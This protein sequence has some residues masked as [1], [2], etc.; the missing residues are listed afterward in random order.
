M[1]PV[2]P[3]TNISEIVS[4]FAKVCRL[5]SIGVFSSENQSHH[6]QNICI[7]NA[8]FC[9][10]VSD[11]TDGTDMVGEKVH[12]QP[13]IGVLNGG[14]VGVG[15]EI[16]KLFDVVSALKAA[17]VELQKAHIPYDPD[18]IVAANGLVVTQLEALCKIKRAYKEKLFSKAKLNGSRLDCVKKEIKVNEKLLEKLKSEVKAKDSEIVVLRQKLEDL[19]SGIKRLA[20]KMRQDRLEKKNAR[21]ALNVSDFENAFVAASKSV[22]DFARPLI[23]LMKASGWDLDQAAKS[24]EDEVFY[25]KRS[26]KKYAFEAY[27]A[28]RMFHGMSL[29]S[30]DVHD[31]MRLDDPMDGL[32]EN[33][34]SGFAKFCREKYLL[35]VH[36]S[37]EASFFGNLD[38]RKFVSI[39]KHPR[40]PFYQIFVKMA[41][42]VWVLQ[43]IAAMIDAEVKVFSVKRGSKFSCVYMESVEDG[44]GKVALDE[45]DVSHIVQFMVIPGF[46]IGDIVVKSRVYL[47]KAR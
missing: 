46:R 13:P 4:R 29:E 17:Y 22:H 16:S 3:S 15:V 30:L 25:S 8:P 36:P 23:S 10:D 19:D 5:R 38:H 32:I 21:R 45:G 6:P 2:K 47:S 31:V 28:R 37:M 35:V 24:V 9:E 42:W 20:E 14:N 12:P 41:R 34:G 39:G 33:P 18:K 7:K 26:D 11:K 27:I 43:G 1:K 40:T 44:E